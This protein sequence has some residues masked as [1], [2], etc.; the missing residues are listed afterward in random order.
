MSE[1]TSGTQAQSPLTIEQYEALRRPLNG[2]RIAKRTQSGQQLSYLEAWDVK[3]HLTRVFGYG[4]WSF[5]IIETRLIGVL[6]VTVGQQNREGWEPMW[7]ARGTLVIPQLG[8]SYTEG[9]VGSATGSRAGGG[10]GLGDLHDNALKQAASDALKRCAIS[11]GTQFGLSLY[12]S[13]ATH[14]V[15]KGTLVKPV[16]YVE[17]E[18]DPK[19]QAQV[20]RALHGGQDE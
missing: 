9:A 7:Y 18:A 8:C 4:G 19:R 5:D 10:G 15:V 3:A 16:G 12:N 11:L 13:G 6:D 1:T 20:D 14:D 17:P 2:T